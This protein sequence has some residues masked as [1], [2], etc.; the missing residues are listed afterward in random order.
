MV[1]KLID[2][3][4]EKIL[5]KLEQTGE[6]MMTKKSR[7]IIRSAATWSAVVSLI[8]LWGF[9]SIIIVFI[10]WNMY[11]DVCKQ[12]KVPFSFAST[13]SYLPLLITTIKFIDVT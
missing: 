13:I 8:P 11:H 12:M 3:G 4:G 6:L 7:S 1:D 9:E 10:L 5:D 2:K